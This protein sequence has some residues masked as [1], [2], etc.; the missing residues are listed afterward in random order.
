ME[1]SFS[2]SSKFYFDQI[3]EIRYVQ[4]K[5]N[6]RKQ[7]EINFSEEI[8]ERKA[9]VAEITNSKQAYQ[10]RFLLSKKYYK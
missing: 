3:S 2:H 7:K 6:L 10:K 9:N 1:Y 5:R 4:R 8:L